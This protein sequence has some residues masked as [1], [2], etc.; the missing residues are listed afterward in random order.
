MLGVRAMVSLSFVRRPR[1]FSLASLVVAKEVGYVDSTG[2]SG[3]GWCSVFTSH[4][5]FPPARSTSQSS[6]LKGVASLVTADKGG[7]G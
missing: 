6:A 5:A 3:H 1:L 4:R 2:G 7:F